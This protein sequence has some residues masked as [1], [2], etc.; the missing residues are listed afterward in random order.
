MDYIVTI[1]PALLQG[2]GLTL[3]FFFL[4]LVVSVPLGIVVALGVISPVPPLKWFLNF[5]ILLMRGTPLLLQ[6]F[7]FYYCLPFVN[8]VIPPF[9][10]GALAF[11]LNYAAY[12]AEIFRAGIQ[13]IDKGQ[14]ESAKVLGMTYSQTMF[15]VIIPQMARRVLP[16]VSNEAITLVKDTALISSITMFDL[17]HAAK[18]AVVRDAAITAFGVAALFYLVFIG[19]L[20]LAGR[21]LEKRFTIPE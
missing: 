19:I 9:T 2:F 15:R 14:F 11:T 12:F 1:L 8:I 7:F 18:A 5:Y 20:T 21:F 6:I 4:V 13:S 16:P 3:R 10:A 17:L